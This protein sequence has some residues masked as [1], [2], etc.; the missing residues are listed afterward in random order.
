MPFETAEVVVI[1]SD[2]VELLEA[3]CALIVGFV[4]ADGAPLATRGWGLTFSPDRRSAR[5]LI[6]ADAVEA[7]GRVSLIGS[8][9]GVTGCNVLT[10]VSRQ[11]KGPVTSVR[12]ADTNDAAVLA[13]YC[14]A[15]FDDVAVVDSIP[16]VLMERLI[17][18][19][20]VACDFEVAE[21]FDQS[22]GPGAGSPLDIGAP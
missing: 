8:Q 9:V 18:S 10:L 3:G 14:D 15:F 20:V 16:R 4:T 12:A 21:V 17:P 13:R 19:A 5:L 6:G 7:L 11:V 1:G 22:P 2:A